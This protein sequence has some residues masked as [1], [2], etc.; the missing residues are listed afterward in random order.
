MLILLR[1][2]TLKN[3]SLNFTESLVAV[4]AMKAAAFTWGDVHERYLA[5]AVKFADNFEGWTGFG[6]L[7]EVN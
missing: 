2:C 6:P 7:D 1:V 4:R 3:T 5:A